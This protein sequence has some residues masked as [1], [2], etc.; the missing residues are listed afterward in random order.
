MRFTTDASVLFQSECE[1]FYV[2]RF[3]AA[4]NSTREAWALHLPLKEYAANILVRIV[5]LTI[6]LDDWCCSSGKINEVRSSSKMIDAFQ[7][8]DKHTIP[9]HQFWYVSKL[10]VPDSSVASYSLSMNVLKSAM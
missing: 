10:Q 9:T 1:T 8:E 5:N 6:L 3:M 7:R 4:Y 2:N